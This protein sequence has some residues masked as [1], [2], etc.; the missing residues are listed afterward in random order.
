MKMTMRVNYRIILLPLLEKDI[1]FM[2]L[3]VFDQVNVN[4]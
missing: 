4:G 2:R 3:I 1:M